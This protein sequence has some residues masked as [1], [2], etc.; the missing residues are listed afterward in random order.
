VWPCWTLLVQQT[1]NRWRRTNPYSFSDDSVNE[2]VF[3]SPAVKCKVYT[4]NIT[5]QERCFLNASCWDV[6]CQLLAVE[7]KFLRCGTC[8]PTWNKQWFYVYVC[9]KPWCCRRYAGVHDVLECRATKGQC[10]LYFF[11][12]QPSIA[13]VGYPTI[14]KSHLKLVDVALSR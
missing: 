6:P 10:I 4:C 8:Q 13:A 1:E 7:A 2:T 9:G 3:L 11:T 5:L 14:T 12:Q